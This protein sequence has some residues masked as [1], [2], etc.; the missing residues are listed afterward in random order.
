VETQKLYVTSLDLMGMR[1]SAVCPGVHALRLPSSATHNV[2]Y[3]LQHI[4]H[5]WE[6][7]TRSLIHIHT[8]TAE[9]GLLHRLPRE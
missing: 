9:L 2:Y 6:E 4:Y 5:I 3:L 1:P 7:L 8:A